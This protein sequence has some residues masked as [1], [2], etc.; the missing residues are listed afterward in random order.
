[1]AS[2]S[3][4]FG[5]QLD[6]VR[7]TPTRYI[8][9]TLVGSD[10]FWRRIVVGLPLVFLIATPI[11][12]VFVSLAAGVPIVLCLWLLWMSHEFVHPQLTV[13]LESRTLVKSKPYGTGSYS[14]I[15]VDD[16]DHVS[17]IR[18]TDSALVKLHYSSWAV[19]KPL[20]AA[21]G[22]STIDDF[23]ALL[24]HMD[25]EISI[26]ESTFPPLTRSPIHIRIVATPIVILGSL[27]CVWHFYG[28]DAF[29]T[30]AVA[31]PAATLVIYG[32]YGFVWQYRL[33]RSKDE[34]RRENL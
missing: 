23:E 24:K 32:L 25:V 4:V 34:F 10:R 17:V 31:V 18:F 11:H 5:V 27:S 29:S 13:D 33:R 6:R 26:Y 28:A 20:S 14:P 7:D 16:L 1:M 30:G 19:S 21:I 3:S 12:N 2:S 22:A 9:A 15:D 8:F